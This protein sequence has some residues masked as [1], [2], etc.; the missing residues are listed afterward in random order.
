M[1]V[2][3]YKCKKCGQN[4]DILVKGSGQENKLQCPS[5]KS[6]DV[7]KVFSSFGVGKTNSNTSTNVNGCSGGSFCPNCLG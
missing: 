3:S 7:E 1:P 6:E 4:F 2:Y 5:C